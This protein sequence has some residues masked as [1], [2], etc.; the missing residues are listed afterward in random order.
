[1]EFTKIPFQDPTGNSDFARVLAGFDTD[2]DGWG[3]F[4]TGYTDYDSNYIFF[5]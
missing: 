4:L 2:E 5:V 3:E 1:M